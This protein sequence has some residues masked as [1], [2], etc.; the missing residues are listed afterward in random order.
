MEFIKPGTY[1]DFMKY[2]GPVMTVLGIMATLS[3]ISLFYPGPNYGIDFAGGTEVQLV[4]TGD[5]SPAEVRTALQDSGYARPD[6]ISVEDQPNEYIIRVQEV[7]SLPDAQVEKIRESVAAELG[8]GVLQEMKVSPGGDKITL[9]VSGPVNE[10]QLQEALMAGGANVRS[11]NALT[12]SRDPRYE[13][14]LVGVA[15]E[16]MTQLQEQLGSARRRCASCRV[17]RAKGW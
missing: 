8:D 3:L 13:A 16:L 4:F 14:Q 11:I 6:V 15:D 2:R 17:G 9:R 7:S 12:G 5:T 10:Q 1:I